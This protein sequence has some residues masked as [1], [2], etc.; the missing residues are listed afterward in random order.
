MTRLNGEG[1]RL[2]GDGEVSQ[3]AIQPSLLLP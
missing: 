2:P 3:F 1:H